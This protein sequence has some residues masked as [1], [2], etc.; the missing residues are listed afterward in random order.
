MRDQGRHDGRIILSELEDLSVNLSRGL[1]LQ[2]D[3]ALF[4][5]ETRFQETGEDDCRGSV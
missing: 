4:T 1:T 5:E 3:H 2:D